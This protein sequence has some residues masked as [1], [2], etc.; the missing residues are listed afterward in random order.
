MMF[1]IGV[2]SKPFL[3]RMDAS[4]R[5]VQQRIDSVRSHSGS[6][7]VE[8]FRIPKTGGERIK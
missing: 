5:L 3:D 2:Y 1:W 4:I 7:R 8:Q 6:Y